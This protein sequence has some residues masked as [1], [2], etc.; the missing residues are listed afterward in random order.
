[1]TPIFSS[2]GVSGKPGA[3]QR[4]GGATL[5][6]TT[7]TI[8]GMLNDQQRNV[9]RT[10][11][12][13]DRPEPESRLLELLPGVNANRVNRALKTVQSFHLIEIRTQPEGDPLLRLHP[14]IREFVRTA[15][16][17]KD[18]EK[19][20]GTILDFLDLKIGRFKNLLAQEPSYEILEHWVRKAE[21]QITFGHFEEATSTIDE[22]AGP[23]V[24]RG[25]PEEMIRLTRRLLGDIDWAVACSSYK[26]FDDVF[27]ECLNAMIQIGHDAS[28][29]LLTR[30]EAAIP[31]KSSQFILLCNLRCY[32]YWYTGK[33]D[34]AR[35]G[36][37]AHLLRDCFRSER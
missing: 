35:S 30:Y 6:D 28:A 22:I 17:K 32:A 31:G 7:K 16:P 34:L 13:L 2:N 24:N 10:M 9:L 20:V 18:R 36:L 8:G 14:I 4:Q 19:Y 5:P 27:Q 11:A 37:R 29:D 33:Y 25:Y 3:V 26:D 23:M 21:L 12:E 1:M 15:F